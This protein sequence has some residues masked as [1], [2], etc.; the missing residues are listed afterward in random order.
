MPEFSKRNSKS[1]LLT[2]LIKVLKYSSPVRKPRICIFTSYMN[3]I[4][5]LT[6][7][8]NGLGIPA[9]K[10]DKVFLLFERMHRL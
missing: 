6:V 7:R 10:Q 5:A 3:G 1:I 2:L 4:L 9:S 8:D